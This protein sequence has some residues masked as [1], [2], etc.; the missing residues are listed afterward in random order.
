MVDIATRFLDL[1]TGSRSA[2]AQADVLGQKRG[3]KQQAKYEIIRQPLTLELIQNH[4]DGKLGVGS[5]PIDETNHCRFGALDIDD[6]HLDH[7]QL[8]AK[9]KRFKLPLI[10]C[11]SKSGGAHL[12]LFMT[13]SISCAEM[14]DRLAEFASVLGWGN[15]EIFPRQEEIKVER[16]DTGSS[17]NLPYQNAKYTTRYAVRKDGS[18]LSLEEFVELAEKSR[19]T[20]KQLVE[21]KLGKKDILPD[22]PPC[23]QQL[24]E[25]G[26]PEGGRNMTLLNI[27][28]YYKQAAPNDWKGLL[29][30]HNQDYC[31][32]PLPAREVVSIQEQLNKKEYYYTCK[33]EPIH[34]HC[35]KS[36]CRS[37]KYGVGDAETFPVLGG[38]MSMDRG[39]N[40]R[41]SSYRCR[42]NSS[43][44]AWSRC[45]RCRR[46]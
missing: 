3:S 16:G 46:G 31:S 27:G 25:Y 13:E 40:S 36:L 45:T 19:I 28:I 29:E 9:I 41:P 22:G 20:A 6:Y 21:I 23:C 43:E 37:R 15:A 33:Q 34:S 30:K 38:L 35:N 32:P 39:S 17:L 26:I 24:T 12:Y 8:L 42:W 7:V 44:H 1:F 18:S 11:R 14:R 2:H 5:I 4:L 10:L